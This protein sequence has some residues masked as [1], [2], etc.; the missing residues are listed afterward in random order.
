MWFVELDSRIAYLKDSFPG[1]DY[2]I[3]IHNKLIF[4]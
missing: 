1:E 2:D 4:F 3:S